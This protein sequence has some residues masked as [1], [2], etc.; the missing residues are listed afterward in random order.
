MNLPSSLPSARDVGKVLGVS[1]AMV[2]ELARSGK[3]PSVRFQAWA[4]GRETVR[5]RWEDVQAFIEGH[6]TQG[7]GAGR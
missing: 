3:L 1:S 5:F 4:G 7:K 6:L 2:Y